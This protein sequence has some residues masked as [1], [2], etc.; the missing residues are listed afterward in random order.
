MIAKH[1]ISLVGVLLA[2]CLYGAQANAEQSQTEK[3]YQAYCG[4]C[5]GMNGDGKGINV[6]DMSTQ[7]RDHTDPEEMS[8][9]SDEELFTAIKEGGQAVDKSVLMPPWEDT[10]TDE[11]IWDL[12]KYLR[13]LCGCE[14]GKAS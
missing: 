1:R 5:H 13:A 14:Y 4:Q 6:R 11:E 10:F 2:S 12:V 9:R 8:A 3:N 7:P